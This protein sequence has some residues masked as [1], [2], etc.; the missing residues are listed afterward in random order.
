MHIRK[1]KV[2]DVTAIHK[3]LN[4]Y[5]DQDLLLARPLS[6]LYDHLRDFFV[7]ESANQERPIQGVCGLGICWEDLAEIKSLALYEEHQGKGFGAQFVETCFKEARSLGL[8]KLFAL[9]YVPDF[10]IKLGFTK[11]DKSLLPHKIWAD[12]VRCPK[13]PKCDETA[14]IVD[15]Y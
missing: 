13:F 6:E 15:L 11:V 1:A 10:F 3:I 14:L 4:H 7:L 12:C 2:G 5:A 8:R 9:T